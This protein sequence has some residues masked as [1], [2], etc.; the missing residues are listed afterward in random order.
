MNC[1]CEIITRTLLFL[2]CFSLNVRL[3]EADKLSTCPVM[4]L[5]LFTFPIYNLSLWKN[6][7]I[8]HKY[9]DWN[10]PG[11]FL[12]VCAHWQKIWIKTH[13]IKRQLG[14]VTSARN[15]PDVTSACVGGACDWNRMLMRRSKGFS[16]T[17]CLC[18]DQQQWQQTSQGQKCATLQ[19]RVPVKQQIRGE[20]RPRLNRSVWG[21][22]QKPRVVFTRIQKQCYML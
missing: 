22:V 16:H 21:Q 2:W 12:P 4:N 13:V 8:S 5:L 7:S 1:S 10:R 19:T 6:A 18:T 14:S 9:P 17:L 15:A 3:F 20:Q 11:Y